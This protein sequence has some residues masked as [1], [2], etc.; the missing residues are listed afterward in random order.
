ME[1]IFKSIVFSV[2]VL[3]GILQPETDPA[4]AARAYRHE[5][6]V[7][8]SAELRNCA[9][10][11][12]SKLLASGNPI[13]VELA[14]AVRTEEAAYGVKPTRIIAFDPLS[15]LYVVKDSESAAPY[16]LKDRD[17]ALELFFRIYGVKVV[18]LRPASAPQESPLTSP[19]TDKARDPASEP[20][21]SQPPYLPL[22]G[23]LSVKMKASLYFPEELGQDPSVLWNYKKP[24]KE[25]FFETVE[26]IPY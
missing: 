15:E 5:N 4:L 17:A 25:F 11:N 26:E 10:P 21:G 16:L 19:R 2:G 9:G 22:E 3:L 8:V 24:A 12:F 13:G 1:T 18:R 14:F 6:A 7:Y 23:W 20:S